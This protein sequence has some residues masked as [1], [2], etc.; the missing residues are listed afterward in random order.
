MLRV[1]SPHN[2]IEID[3]FV[4]GT[5]KIERP[6]QAVCDR[7]SVGALAEVEIWAT[8]RLGPWRLA[9]VANKPGDLTSF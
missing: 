1:A 6:A 4:C 2:A 9:R 7:F 5:P 8:L 3:S